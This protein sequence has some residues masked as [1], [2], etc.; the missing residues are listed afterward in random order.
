M[1]HLVAM[2]ALGHK[3][4]KRGSTLRTKMIISFYWS[5]AIWAHKL[6]P[7]FAQWGHPLRRLSLMIFRPELLDWPVEGL[8]NG[9]SNI[10]RISGTGDDL[11]YKRLGDTKFFGN[12]GSIDAGPHHFDSYFNSGSR[13]SHDLII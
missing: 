7:F 11:V 3:T 6:P 8:R 5:S 9:I 12:L 1:E 10:L 4:L 2:A 13:F